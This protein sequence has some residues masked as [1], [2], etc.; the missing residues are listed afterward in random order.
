MRLRPC[1]SSWPV[2][3][4]TPL[5]GP[6]MSDLASQLAQVIAS[7]R[8]LTLEVRRQGR[9]LAA[10][11]DLVESR[12]DYQLV[13]DSEPA[14]SA[15]SQSPTR[16]STGP[17]AYPA[18]AARPAKPLALSRNPPPSAL[19]SESE[20]RDIAQAVGGFFRRALD[21]L[22]RGDSGRSR[23]PLASR[24]YL[25]I[26]D[27]SG[28]SFKPP[29]LVHSYTAARRHCVSTLASSEIV[30]FVGSLRFGRLE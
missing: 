10:L 5:S 15:P 24:L 27:H 20:R 14:R 30:S 18:P 17:A 26:R 23:N 6:F 13:P 12:V 8:D 22:H 16:Q 29:L 19:I 3:C 28:R 9:D 2:A 11:H 25:V 4:S 1:T 21:G 7:L